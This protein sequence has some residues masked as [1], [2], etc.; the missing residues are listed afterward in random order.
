MAEAAEGTEVEPESLELEATGGPVPLG[1]VRDRSVVYLIANDRTARWPTAPLRNGV[2]SL[3]IADRRLRGSVQLVTDPVRKERVLTAFRAR[4]GE[5]RFARWYAHPAKVLAVRIGDKNRPATDELGRYH[6]WLAAE[7][8]NVADDYDRHITGNRINR[9]LR[10]RSLVELRRAFHGRPRLLEVGCGSGT[11]TMP[12]IADGHELLCVDIS[13]RMLEVVR[14]KARRAG[15][16][17][18]L[19]TRR[20]AL[21]DLPSLLHDEGPAAFDGAYSTYGA[22]NCE[23]DL[24][25]LPEALGELLRPESRF[26]AGVY[27]RWCAFELAGYGVTGRWSRAVARTRRPVPVGWSRFCV[28]T[29]ALSAGEFRRLFEPRFS[30]ERVE[31][32]PVVIPPSDLVAYTD[33]MGPRFDRLARV[34]RWLGR[35]WPFSVL[36][37]HFLMTLRR[38]DGGTVGGSRALSRPAP[39]GGGPS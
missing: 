39:S 11:E 5:R 22:L 27:N 31:G 7:F 25:A 3:R 16:S 37:D 6:A 35:W 19:A 29:F 4:Y 1:F 10:D 34:D 36:G 30:V 33:A 12:L 38:R 17:E 13:E 32:V 9:L 20:M 18:R 28:D 23:A 2:A 8:D 26:V 24:R 21:A 15:L 14:A